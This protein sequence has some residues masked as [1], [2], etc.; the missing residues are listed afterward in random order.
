MNPRDEK[1]W[2][3]IGYVPPSID[4]T[5]SAT[6]DELGT[7]I[8]RGLIKFNT[9]V[10]RIQTVLETNRKR[11]YSAEYALT[12]AKRHVTVSVIGL[13]SDKELKINENWEI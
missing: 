8:S 5:C 13:T 11:G 4:A 6:W 10:E 2:N 9:E 1:L 7:E 3:P 12:E